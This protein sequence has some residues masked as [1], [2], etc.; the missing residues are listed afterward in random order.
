MRPR[1]HPSDA[2]LFDY[3]AGALD[4]VC[5]FVI[6]RHIAAC[7]EC[8]ESLSLAEQ[9]GALLL[10]A[11]EGAPLS[12][13]AADALRRRMSEPRKAEE[14]GDPKRLLAEAEAKLKPAPSI[15][16][17]EKA[18]IAKTKTHT[19]QLVRLAPKATLP[20]HSHE[21]TEYIFVV[22]GEM[23]IKGETYRPGDICESEA[24]DVHEP[25]VIGSGPCTYLV[26]FEGRILYRG[27]LGRLAYRIFG[28]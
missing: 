4:P 13:D 19:L 10:S 17:L 3:A 20:A 6:E 26:A 9:L 25:R 14:Y 28:V 23:E 7:D 24:C 2:T 21:G 15:P 8:I 11:G 12:P 16:G 27:L 18:V 22:S 1:H 5:A